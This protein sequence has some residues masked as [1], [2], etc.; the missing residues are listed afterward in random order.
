MLTTDPVGDEEGTLEPIGKALRSVFQDMNSLFHIGVSVLSHRGPGKSFDG[1]LR[2]AFPWLL[3]ATRRWLVSSRANPEGAQNKD[4]RTLRRLKLRNYRLPGV[5]EINLSE[6]RV[7]LIY[8]PN[9]SGKSSIAEALEVVTCGTVERLV[10]AGVDRYDD[11]HQALYECYPRATV[12]LGWSRENV[13]KYDDPRTIVADGVER[14][15]DKTV[16]VASFRLDQPVMDRLISHSTHERAKIFMDAFFPKAASSRGK[17]EQ[18]AGVHQLALQKVD[19]LVDRLTIAR[20]S[21]AELQ[22]HKASASIAT[23]DPFPSVL[24]EWL[25]QTGA[26]WTSCSVQRVVRATLDAAQLDGWK[27][28]DGPG[29]AAVSALAG[30]IDLA[31]LERFEQ[32]SKAAVDVLQAKLESFRETTEVNAAGAASPVSRSVVESLNAVS[33]FLSTLR[34]TSKAMAVS[35]TRSLPCST[36][37]ARRHT[38]RS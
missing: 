20:Q 4:G 37:A 35:A 27:A 29:G 9:G 14:P 33:P 19:A 6:A 36:P 38:D 23:S 1:Q 26:R 18:A 32:E 13:V 3:T 7:H 22:E 16:H 11:V 12:V 25:E 31:A 28:V 15:L 2:R 17:Y 5:R 10:Q 8:G 24:N 30:T 21:L 34:M